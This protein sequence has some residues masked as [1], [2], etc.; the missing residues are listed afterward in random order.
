MALKKNITN[1]SIDDFNLLIDLYKSKKYTK[2]LE[3]IYE[4]IWQ[5]YQKKL[6][7]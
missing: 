5:D 1:I 3:K 4:K 6:S 7:I 2:N